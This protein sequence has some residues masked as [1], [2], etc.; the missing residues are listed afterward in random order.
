MGN[1][2]SSDSSHATTFSPCGKQGWREDS[3]ARSSKAQRQ[4]EHCSQLAAATDASSKPT[5]LA[6]RDLG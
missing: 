4:A 3:V 6:R 1:I 5:G 2:S